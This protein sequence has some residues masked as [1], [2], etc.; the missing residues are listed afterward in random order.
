MKNAIMMSLLF[1]MAGMSGCLGDDEITT[2]TDTTPVINSME[3]NYTMSHQFNNYAPMGMGNDTQ[4]ELNATNMSIWLDINISADFHQPLLWERG[5]VNLSILDDN[6][7]LLWSN[8]T[9]EGQ[10]NFTV[11]IS[12]NFT[13]DGNLTLRTMAD[14]SDNATD[15]RV[16]DWYVIRVK[17][18]C[19]WRDA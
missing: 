18:M 12:E 10:D 9:S 8:K 11:W 4:V 14:G 7:T 13:Y 19:D 16:A 2:P 5:S 3:Y 17:I 15:D 6:N 1:L